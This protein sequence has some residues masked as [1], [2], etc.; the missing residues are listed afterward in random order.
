M[1]LKLEYAE[2]FTVSLGTLI[3]TLVSV[4]HTNK[5]FLLKHSRFIRLLLEK[6][7][8]RF[9]EHDRCPGQVVP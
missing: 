9:E 2:I 3:V 5:M 6:H 7:K 4:Q 1:T 8:V